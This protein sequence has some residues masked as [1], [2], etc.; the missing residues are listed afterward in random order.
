[1]K[2]LLE[3]FVNNQQNEKIA[4]VFFSPNFPLYSMAVVVVVVIVVVAIWL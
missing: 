1:M 4:N 2:A 3:K